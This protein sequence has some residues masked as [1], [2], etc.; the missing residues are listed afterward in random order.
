MEETKDRVKSTVFKCVI[1]VE[2]ISGTVL[3]G[4]LSGAS[5][6]DIFSNV[7]TMIAG[8]MVFLYYY[9]LD[10][11]R[12][13]AE[14]QQQAVFLAGFASSVIL[15]AFTSRT[16]TGTIW[17]LAVAVAGITGGMGHAVSCHA[18]LLL[19]YLVLSADAAV[20]IRMVIFYAVLGILFALVMSETRDKKSFVYS[21]VIFIALTAVMVIILY[22]FDPGAVIKDK[23][24]L[25]RCATGDAILVA[26]SY[27]MITYCIK[28]RK[29]S[30][31]SKV[32]YKRQKRRKRDKKILESLIGTDHILSKRIRH[33]SEDLYSHS[34]RISQLSYKAAK[35][36]GCDCLLAGAGGMYHEA[37]RIYEDKDYV[38]AC[39]M[40]AAEYSFPK[41]LYDIVLQ[42]G[43]A[44]EKP[45]SSEAAIV[46][47]SDN[48]ITT[49]EYLR[50]AG[51][52]EQIS[53]EKLVRSVFSNRISKGNFDGSGMDRKQINQ[54]M[55]FY[56]HNAFKDWE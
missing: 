26:A 5:Y 13:I 33:Y 38:E 11:G 41:G 23:G 42:Y 43:D 31:D 56:I 40:L 20:N 32:Q 14:I 6:I 55:E 9:S 49:D 47:I 29:A 35:Y 45:K 16:D 25:K 52:R 17:L 53:D 37:S 1:Y 22:N 44:S 4:I 54:L 34:L 28:D 19:Q 24:F 36:M 27:I 2:V 10:G 7:A 39:K 48:I 21:S 3:G 15:V 46:M 12:R 8:V 51:K 50:K 18:L 30:K